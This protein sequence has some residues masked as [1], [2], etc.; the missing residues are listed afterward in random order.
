MVESGGSVGADLEPLGAFL[1]REVFPEQHAV[2][3]SGLSRPTGGASW[4]TFFVD[5]ELTR[6]GKTSETRVALRRAPETGP[7][8][9]YEVSK[10]V[11]IF[12]ALA[13]SECPVPPLL[14][15]TED[16]TVFE[17]P[18]SVT[19]FVTGESPDITKVE[20]WPLWQEQREALGF[21]IVDTLAAL[22][23]FDWQGSGVEDVLG[24]RGDAAARVAG[25]VDRYLV[26]LLEDARLAA[27]GLPFLR[28]LGSWL[29]ANAPDV[30]EE[31]LVIVHGDYRFGNLL[32][33]GTKIRAVLDWER[34]MMGP[35]MQ[36][37]GFLCMPLSRIRD[38]QMMAKALSF[39]ALCKRYEEASGQPVDVAQVQY[40][41]VL[42]QF[43]EGVNSARALVKSP[44]TLV[45]TGLLAQPN[46][47]TRQTLKLIDDY[48][49][50]R[51]VL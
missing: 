17:R 28:D 15:W 7:M 20:T 3:V 33:E 49:A 31:D 10:D 43:L 45:A 23:R 50:G 51:R 16:P 5:L 41:A 27:L 37:L 35:R 8:A 14:A 44:P 38:P 11:A 22:H 1:H 36:D 19:G 42:W 4:E 46:L 30:P 18:F 34:A 6:G 24:P 13:K 47:V 39:D 21:E 40:Y 2:R 9:P 25:V 29:K 12:R 26:P 32:W 48:E